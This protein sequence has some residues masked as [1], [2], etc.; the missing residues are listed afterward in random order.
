MFRIR[1]INTHT[2]GMKDPHPLFL[3]LRA[4]HKKVFHLGGALIFHKETNLLNL[5]A[6]PSNSPIM[7]M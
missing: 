6:F 4:L 1:D 7:S 5:R 2:L 3:L